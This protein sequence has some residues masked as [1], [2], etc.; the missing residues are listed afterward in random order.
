MLRS[1]HQERVRKFM[2]LAGQN[3][4]DSPVKTMDSAVKILRIRLLMEELLETAD[5]LGV[6]INHDISAGNGGPISF[7]DLDFY[8][9]GNFDLIEAVDGA[10]DI[11]VVNQGLLIALGVADNP[12]LEEIDNNNLAKFGPGGY[13]DE[14]GKWRKPASHKPPNISKAIGLE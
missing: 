8:D 1:E 14:N 5:A 6:V 7:E 2:Q 13:R 10:G 12:V 4:P 3:C 11:S 9:N